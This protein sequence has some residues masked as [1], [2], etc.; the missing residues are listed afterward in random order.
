MED[1]KTNDLTPERVVQI[2]KKKE[3][4]SILRK[5][6]LSWYLSRKLLILQ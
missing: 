5:R 4:R 2:L 1:D 3:R 6:K